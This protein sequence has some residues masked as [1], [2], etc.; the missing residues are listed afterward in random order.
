MQNGS[1]K[2]QDGLYRL[3]RDTG[4]WA[5]TPES[6]KICNIYQQRVIGDEKHL[7]V[8]CPAQDLR[9]KAL[10]LFADAQAGA[11]ILFMWQRDMIDVVRFTAECVESVRVL[12]ISSA[13]SQLEK[14]QSL[15]L[16]L[17][18]PLWCQQLSK[19]VGLTSYGHGSTLY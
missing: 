3:P 18:S 17:S 8:E 2:L 15:S 14:L 16:S 13:L 19:V 7:V 9:N 4:A 11:S 6:P 10:H 1:A 12:H 5:G